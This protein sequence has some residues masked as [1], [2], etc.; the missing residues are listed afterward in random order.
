M[1]KRAKS[2]FRTK[3][4]EID[5]GQSV[6][7]EAKYFD[8]LSQPEHL[9]YSSLLG[10]KLCGRESE[11]FNFKSYLIVFEDGGRSLIAKTKVRRVEP[12]LEDTEDTSSDKNDEISFQIVKNVNTAVTTNSV[13][14]S[15]IT[16]S[17]NCITVSSSNPNSDVRPA[18]TSTEISISS[19]SDVSNH[20]SMPKPDVILETDY[21]TDK[22]GPTNIDTP[23]SVSVPSPDTLNIVLYDGT[24]TPV[25]KP[26]ALDKWAV[27]TRQQRKNNAPDSAKQIRDKKL[28]K[29]PVYEDEF[30]LLSDALQ[31]CDA[32]S[33]DEIDVVL[34]PPEN[35]DGDTDNE[36]RN[37]TGLTYI[38][39]GLV[40]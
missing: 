33:D 23:D 17:E 12:S 25:E 26:E 11:T 40:K 4:E 32:I 10:K 29:S 8:D 19:V 37:D 7:V 28:K 15:T 39:V 13:F 24:I 21:V 18:T 16:S 9:R 35:V 2:R 3:I 30:F 31:E 22:P 27:T 6:M 36:C 5:N 1:A 34:L 14:Q 20:L 38:Y